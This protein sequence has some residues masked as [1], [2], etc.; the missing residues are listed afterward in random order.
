MPV[1]I[2]RDDDSDEQ[3]ALLC[4]SEWELPT[5]LGELEKWLE[6]NTDDVAPG[7]IVADIGYWVREDASG[8]GAV[9][10]AASMRKFS[11]M[12]IHIYFSE[13]PP[14][15]GADERTSAKTSLDAKTRPDGDAM[16]K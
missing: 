4:Q 5:Q 15:F 8:G 7:R 1:N 2:Y 10:S 6:Q 13:Y 16:E 14:G 11:D 9:L 3:I 12:G